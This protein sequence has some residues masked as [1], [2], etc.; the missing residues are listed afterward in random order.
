MTH[1]T[2]PPVKMAFLS[3]PRQSG[4]ER[5][6]FLLKLHPEP[7]T[8]AQIEAVVA[9]AARAVRCVD[10]RVDPGIGLL[11]HWKIVVSNPSFSKSAMRSM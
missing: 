7:V 2:G 10:V 8:R 9:S 3:V 11:D 5:A 1:R 4:S 6:L